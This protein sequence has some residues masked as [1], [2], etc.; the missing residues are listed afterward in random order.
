M[1]ISPIQVQIA[2]SF[3][4]GAVSPRA[5]IYRSDAEHFN[6]FQHAQ[7]LTEYDLKRF[8]W[9]ARISRT[10]LSTGGYSIKYCF[11]DGLANWLPIL[12]TAI[13]T[14]RAAQTEA[15]AV[16]AVDELAKARPPTAW[17]VLGVSAA[18]KLMFFGVPNWPI[19]IFD[20]FS[21]L[22]VGLQKPASYSIWHRAVSARYRA[23]HGLPAALRSRIPPQPPFDWFQRRCFDIALFTEGRKLEEARRH[24]SK[25]RQ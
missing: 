15:H 24:Q 17:K 9:F 25:K 6:A 10:K 4:H 8:I 22:A 5:K 14:G 11:S 16:R 7:N 12:R 18:S 2:N 21:G 13:Q 20:R 3:W 23:L 19:F 1:H